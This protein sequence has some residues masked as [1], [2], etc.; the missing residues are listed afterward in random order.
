ML[1][2]A[3]PLM[4]EACTAI[5]ASMESACPTA[6]IDDAS[7][8]DPKRDVFGVH[9]YDGTLESSVFFV[10]RR[11]QEVLRFLSHYPFQPIHDQHRTSFL[12]QD[13]RAATFAYGTSSEF[14]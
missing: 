9:L 14:F 7:R 3:A 12:D 6:D 5:D 1:D 2:T 13:R 8:F 4:Q 11:N 10:K